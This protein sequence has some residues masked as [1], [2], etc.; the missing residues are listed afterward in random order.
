MP[1]LLSASEAAGPDFIC[2]GAQKAG[3]RWLF[4]QLAFHPGLW[5]PPIKELHYFNQSK[6]FLRFARPLHENAVRSLRSTNRRRSRAAERPLVEEDIGWLEARMWLHGQPLDL[7]L[8]ARLFN[9]KG[10]RL[11]G[12]ICPPYAILAAESAKA[13]RERFPAARIV[14]LVRDP[15]DRLWSQ[16]CM[17]LRR[18]PKE[19][20]ES[21]ETVKA[22]VA[23]GTGRAHSSMRAAIA[24]WR[25]GPDDPGF[26]L[27]FFDYDLDSR[28]DLLTANGHLESDISKVQA[29]QSYEQSA[30]L[31][32]NT[33]ENGRQLFV[34]VD[35]AHAGPDLFK[36][37]VGRGSA[38]ADIDGDGDLDVVITSNGGAARLLR[39][40][41]GDKNGWVR[42][43][44]KGTQSNRNG[45]GAK[46]AVTT[47]DVT[48]TRQLFPSKGYLSSVELPLTFGLGKAE[49]VDRV[50]VTWP[51]GLKQEWKDLRSGTKTTLEETPG[52]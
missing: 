25:E 3:T 38:Y 45:I 28:L 5:M 36:P 43:T 29:S 31:F 9:P 51:S 1:A 17:I 23:H 13:V 24:R 20:P 10:G 26:G 35:E 11:S 41:G 8:Y 6:R 37:L 14:Y 49:K 46:V 4:D 34:L 48:Q 47:G 18:K 50:E 21:L 39:N 12:D 33:G 19:A 44:L 7:D 32:W 16:Y 42:L 52:K 2:V 27:F 30:Q 22:F 40:D 15:I